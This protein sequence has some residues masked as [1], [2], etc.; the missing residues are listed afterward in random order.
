[1]SKRAKLLLREN[2]ELEEQIRDEAARAALTDMIVY[3]RSANISAYNQELVR[4]DI[5]QM[6][7]DG[8]RR[9]ASVEEIIGGDY[10]ASELGPKRKY[11]VLTEKGGLALEEF[12]A[13]YAEL[14]SAVEHLLRA[15]K[16]GE[17]D[18]QESETAAAGE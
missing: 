18:E 12:I 2:N 10:K 17:S 5:W 7:A 16:G 13:S 14:A 11:Y 8:E 9:G 15:V 1:M 3:I 4:R 6:I